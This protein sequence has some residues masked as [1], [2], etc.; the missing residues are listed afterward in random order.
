LFTQQLGLL[1]HREGL[2][3]LLLV[4]DSV[5]PDPFAGHDM[6]EQL[7][8]PGLAIGL[9]VDVFDPLPVGPDRVLDQAL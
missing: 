9:G 7:F 6:A 5:E 4:Q 2:S 8:G 3:R 1:P